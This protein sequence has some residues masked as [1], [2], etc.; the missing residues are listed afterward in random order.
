MQ[1]EPNTN[2]GVRAG[3]YETLARLLTR[4]SEACGVTRGSEAAAVVNE[5]LDAL[6]IPHAEDA[7]GNLIATVRPAA[8]GGPHLLLDAHLDE[9]AFVVTS[10]DDGGFVH[11]DKAGG[12]DARILA[13]HEVTIFGRARLFGVFAS[14]PPH[15]AEKGDE[16]RLPAAR[17]VAVD[18]GLPRD[19]AM[20]LVKPGDFVFL[21]RTAAMLAGGSLPGGLLTGKALDN[22]GGVAVLLRA[23][24][25]LGDGARNV[26]VTA[27]FS[28]AEELGERGAKV[29]AFAG[30][31][32]TALI[33]DASHALSR[34]APAEK[35]GEFGKG[36]MLGVS[37]TLDVGVTDRL[38]ALAQEHGVPYQREIMPGDTGTNASVIALS[39]GG[40]RTGLLSFP[41]RNMHTA[42]ET[43]ALCDVEATARLV[44]LYIEDYAKEAA[45]HA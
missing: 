43:V 20:E 26:G 29:S 4:L 2:A 31:P 14:R 19:R 18:I 41:L 30:N 23:L 5:R 38:E 25:L 37:P 22:R 12:I 36:P 42:A 15:L 9:I 17:E 32:D 27:V 28:L 16:N 45:R 34:E 7:M 13:A 8:E 35:C 24:E 10:V 11:V 44:A 3:D 6:G 33:V 40:V 39:R 21:R 1:N